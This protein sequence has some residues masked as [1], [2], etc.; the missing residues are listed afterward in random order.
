MGATPCMT[1]L[2]PG[3]SATV[4]GSPGAGFPAGGGVGILTGDAAMKIQN[5]VPDDAPLSLWYFKRIE[6]SKRFPMRR[7]FV[8]KQ[9]VFWLLAAAFLGAVYLARHGWQQAFHPATSIQELEYFGVRVA[10]FVT[11]LRLIY[12][13]CYRKQFVAFTEGFRLFVDRGVFVRHRGSVP[14]LS[15]TEVYI[16]QDPLDMLF[17][18]YVVHVH[19]SGDPSKKIGMIEGLSARE[20]FELHRFFSEQMSRLVSVGNYP[21]LNPETGEPTWSYLISEA[22]EPVALPIS[23]DVR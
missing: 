17:G 19:A 6:I 4:L 22:E 1:A 7:R 2:I 10:A 23:P 13:D 18:L 9:N 16:R 8:F 21:E 12:W 3:G 20:A 11:A 14:L 5:G 15:F